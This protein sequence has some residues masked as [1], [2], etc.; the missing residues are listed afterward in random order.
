MEDDGNARSFSLTPSRVPNWVRCLPWL[1]CNEE[2]FAHKETANPA[3][4]SEQ[5]YGAREVRSTQERWPL[6]PGCLVPDEAASPL[7]SNLIE[8]SVIESQPRS[9]LV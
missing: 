1:M 2:G 9:V 3:R 5:T 6:V 7:K 8:S 4:R